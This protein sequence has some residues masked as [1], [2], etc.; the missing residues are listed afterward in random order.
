[1]QRSLKVIGIDPGLA[2]TGF[3][4]VQGSGSRIRDYAFGTIRTSK[5]ETLPNR[6]HHI[7]SELCSV[8]NSEKP[9]LMVI[10]GI[11]S[12]K[13]YPKTGIA[14]GKVCGA[15]LLAGAQCGVSAVELPAREAKRILTGNGNA[16]KA[17]MERAVS[18]FLNRQTA[19]TPSHASDALA[20]ALVGLFRYD[21]R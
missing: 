9:D 6:L 19:I 18:H 14:L 21:S 2:D 10:E 16:S 1:L 5:T 12:L 20:F 13:Q 15:I 17:Q 8:L 4:I 3:G 7:F 11:F